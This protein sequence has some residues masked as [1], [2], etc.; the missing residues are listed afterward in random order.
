MSFSDHAGDFLTVLSTNTLAYSDTVKRSQKNQFCKT[1]KHASKKSQSTHARQITGASG[2][3]GMSSEELSDKRS[4]SPGNHSNEE[5]ILKSF[6]NETK[7]GIDAA[8]QDYNDAVS[9]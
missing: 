8:A 5:V 2:D 6:N 4:P 9:S 7:N 1:E 3:S